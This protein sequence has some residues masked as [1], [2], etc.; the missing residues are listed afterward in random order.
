MEGWEQLK[1]A[2]S[3]LSGWFFWFWVKQWRTTIL[4]LFLII[5]IGAFSAYRIPKESFPEINLW[6][7]T[8]VTVYPGWSPEDIDSLITKKIEDK[9]SWLDW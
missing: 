1:R 7:V 3:E 4:I 8:V 2:K 9:I 5:W 6:M